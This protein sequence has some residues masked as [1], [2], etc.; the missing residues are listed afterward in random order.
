MVFPGTRRSGWASRSNGRTSVV[1]KDQIHVGGENDDDDDDVGM[2]TVE[3]RQ[4]IS[5][6]GIQCGTA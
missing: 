3:H 2:S 5:E 4:L 6:A 1:L